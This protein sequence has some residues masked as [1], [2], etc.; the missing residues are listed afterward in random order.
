MASGQADLTD[1]TFTQ[2]VNTLREQGLRV[3]VLDVSNAPDY[4]LHSENNKID[5]YR[6]NLQLTP[7]TE[8]ANVLF[9]TGMMMGPY[10]MGLWHYV[11]FSARD[12]IYELGS[13]IRW[14]SYSFFVN[15]PPARSRVLSPARG[16]LRCVALFPAQN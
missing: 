4:F 12:Y 8:D 15:L 1:A 11:S 5:E 9:T 16:G 14:G 2:V 13:L 6:L 3:S 10:K 7:F